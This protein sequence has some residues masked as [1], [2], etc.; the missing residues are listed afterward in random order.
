MILA[1]KLSPHSRLWGFLFLITFNS[2]VLS[3]AQAEKTHGFSSFNNL[4]YPVDFTHFDYTNA[5][6]SKGGQL[7]LGALGTFDSLNPYIVKGTPVGGIGLTYAR[8]LNEAR[9]RP[10]ESYAFVAEALEVAPDHSSVTFFLNKNAKFSDE[11]PIT[12]DDVIWSFE[13]LRAKGLPLYR[14]YYKN[15]SQV[16]KIDNHT[17]KFTFTTTTNHE[18]PMIIGQLPILPKKYYEKVDF[19]STT[20]TPA[21]T[22]GP[23][24]IESVDPGRSIT[25][26][27]N[28]HW[29][30]ENVP[31]QKGSNNFDRIRLD[32]Y[33]DANTL[34]EA[35]KAGKI[36]LRAEN[37]ARNWATAY[38]FPAVKN[39][40]VVRTEIPNKL[41]GATY[42]LFF[43]TRRP[44][45]EDPLVREAL[46]L[47]LNFKW[48]NEKFFFNLYSRNLS[49]YPNSDFAATG[50]PSATELKL[51]EP[52]K[53]ELP[54]QVFDEVFALPEAGS[55]SEFRKELKKAQSL[56]E[57]AGWT[58][59]NKVMKHKKTGQVLEFE[60]LVGDHTFEK[61]ILTLK[62]A[63]Q[64]IGININVRLLDA[65]S[66]IYRV[67]HL[68]YDMIVGIF[69]QSP[70]LGNEQR[71]FFG[72]ERADN[73][74]TYNYAGIKN[75]VA[76]ALIEQLIQAQSYTELC[77]TAK[78]L[79]R[80]LLW[81]FYMI[82][83]W[84]SS[85][86]FVAYWDKFDHSKT[87]PAYSKLDY[88]S[89]WYDEKKATALSQR[90]KNESESSIRKV[91]LKLKS[92]FL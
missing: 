26:K 71:D 84:H 10:G 25:Y 9:D 3:S 12:V 28:P 86:T 67:E 32:Y 92:F 13:I 66:Y 85:T 75:K 36:D 4:K 6:A 11:T 82:P 68:D 89:W 45:F 54:K 17:V 76:D 18:L 58:L 1:F 40:W 39:G 52:F 61:I 20:L 48:L 31:S 41:P 59:D 24:T 22:S 7:N 74:G 55:E 51:L 15:V 73:I 62:D 77:E 29:W 70:S 46:T 64:R 35:F 80:V 53:S 34:F 81:N 38:N 16:E 21:P 19:T 27:R 8:L 49:Y 90:M 47:C 78:A 43:N 14:T 91:W 65:T 2:L 63:L 44:L 5:E 79:D 50:K 69:L 42:G 56:L 83:A 30:G 57:E 72:S 88:S 60:V 33:M 87:S 23:Y 37:I